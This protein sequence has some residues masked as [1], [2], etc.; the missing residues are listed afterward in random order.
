MFLL[1]ACSLTAAADDDSSGSISV[2][3]RQL[4]KS[5]S[6]V[7]LA[8]LVVVVVVALALSIYLLLSRAPS[9]TK[10]RHDLAL[11]VSEP[12]SR[13]DDYYAAVFDNPVPKI[14]DEKAAPASMMLADPVIKDVEEDMEIGGPEAARVDNAPK[15]GSVD[16][17]LKEDERI[18]MNVLRMKHG[19]CTQATLRVVTDFS[20]ARL[21]RIISELDERGVITKVQQGRKNLVTLKV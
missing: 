21:S 7:T 19:S 2:E 5:L 11:K 1:L 13:R 17:Y 6:L 14:I 9:P 12:A 4:D 10:S 3:I 8:V 20:K 18:V 16:R 15:N